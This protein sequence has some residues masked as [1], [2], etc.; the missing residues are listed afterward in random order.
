MNT[1]NGLT[2]QPFNRTDVDSAVPLSASQLP[3][4]LET[5]FTIQR[6]LLP[7]VFIIGMFGNIISIIIYG[8]A[9]SSTRSSIAISFIALAT[10]DSIQLLDIVLQGITIRFFDFDLGTVNIILCKLMRFFS[11]AAPHM[12]SYILCFMTIQRS[13]SVMW[14]HRANT[15]C[16]PKR[17]KRFLV[18][19]ILFVFLFHSHILLFTTLLIAKN[20]QRFCYFT[21][22]YGEF[23]VI[24]FVWM[25]LVAEVLISFVLLSVSNIGLIMSLRLSMKRAEDMSSKPGQLEARMKKTSSVTMTLIATSVCY[26]LLTMPL[27]LF[28]LVQ[29]VHRTQGRNFMSNGNIMILHTIL[30]TLKNTNAGINFYIY[31]L[32]GSKFRWD[33]IQLMRKC[34]CMKTMKKKSILTKMF[35]D[36]AQSKTETN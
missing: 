36:V 16:A 29:G 31:C 10:T 15:L 2:E 20:G 19:V 28:T 7:F 35:S 4:W 13:I 17:S 25:L 22:P 23:F 8:R 6:W 26:F 1:T 11:Y 27:G 34:L 24:T 21:Y 33:F 18:A 3:E 14:P 5:M 9:L 30:L 32:T 12:S